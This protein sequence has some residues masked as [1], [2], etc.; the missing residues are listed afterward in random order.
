MVAEV[1][2]AGI[3]ALARKRAPRGA[4]AAASS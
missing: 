4:A 2:A 1:F 3:A